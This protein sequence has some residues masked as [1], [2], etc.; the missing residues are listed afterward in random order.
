M[1]VLIKK[2]YFC[3]H[4]IHFTEEQVPYLHA[5]LQDKKDI[6]VGVCAR[7]RVRAGGRVR[8]WVRACLRA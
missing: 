1:L 2:N 3:D 5:S 6:T 8:G 4:T 7:V